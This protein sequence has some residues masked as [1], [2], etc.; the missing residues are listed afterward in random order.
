ML[1]KDSKIKSED[2]E[3]IIGSG[4]KVEGS[5]NAFGNVIVK[6]QLIGSLETQSDLS[7]RD[8]GVIEADIK[9]KNAFIAGEIKGNLGIEE[10]IELASTAKVFGDI[11]CRVLTIEEGAILNGRCKVGGEFSNN[12]REKKKLKEEPADLD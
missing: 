8:T 7:L 12:S 6:G 1:G 9:A 5:F 10:K 11:N 4:V 2:A 3:T